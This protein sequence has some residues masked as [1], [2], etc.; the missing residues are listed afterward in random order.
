MLFYLCVWDRKSEKLT[1]AEYE[2][3]Y[4]QKC[5]FLHHTRMTPCIALPSSDPFCLQN[6]T[7]HMKS[8]NHIYKLKNSNFDNKHRNP[9]SDRSGKWL[10]CRKTRVTPTLRVL[11]LHGGFWVFVGS[12][13]GPNVIVRKKRVWGF[14]R[15][16]GS[17]RKSNGHPKRTHGLMARNVAIAAPFA[18]YIGRLLSLCALD[19][20]TVLFFLFVL[21]NRFFWENMLPLFFAILT[22]RFYF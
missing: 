17:R 19:I 12:Q 14:Q 15:R 2:E 6:P 7:K 16:D 5:V 22:V 4:H 1:G 11:F 8:Q 13:T 3:W 9:E 10:I 18:F 21:F 20:W